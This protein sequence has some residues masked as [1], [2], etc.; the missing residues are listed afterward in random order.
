M[1]RPFVTLTCPSE[2][3]LSDTQ[4]ALLDAIIKLLESEGLSILHDS[5]SGDFKGRARQ[6]K[7]SH[8]CI[9]VAFA[10]WE[11]SRLRGNQDRPYIF[12]T[13]YAHVTSALALEAGRPLFVLKDKQVNERGML[14]GAYLGR[15]AEMPKFATSDWLRSDE[16]ELR[17]KNWLKDVR[18]QKHVFLGYS[19]QARATA[20]EITRYLTEKLDLSVLDWHNFQ[21]GK[22]VMNAIEEAECL[23]ACGIF[24]FMADDFLKGGKSLRGAP[25]DNVVYEAGYFAGA[26]SREHTIIIR[27]PDAKVPSD[28]AGVLYLELS[29]RNDISRIETKLGV[30]LNDLF[31]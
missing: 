19:S 14:K 4:K 29:D 2:K 8:G 1:R 10:Q 13:E 12:T 26:K 15:L 21:P 30:Y 6:V 17:F 27:E 20:N 24:L 9:V 11:A 16:F 18:K 7:R 3:N 31:E 5:P 23:T 28:L 25:R 22:I